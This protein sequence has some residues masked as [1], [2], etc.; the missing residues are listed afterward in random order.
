MRLYQAQ[1]YDPDAIF[2]TKL[3]DTCGWW[4]AY[5]EARF[6][7]LAEVAKAVFGLMAGSGILELHFCSV[8]QL[9]NQESDAH[10][11]PDTLR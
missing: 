11:S 4:H 2:R 10:G 7:V 6:P 9:V 5:G 3:S 8:T 1:A